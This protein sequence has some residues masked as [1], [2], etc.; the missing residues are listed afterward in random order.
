MA[1]SL[2]AMRVNR[3]MKRGQV[4][5]ALNA[6]GIAITENQLYNFEKHRTSPDVLTAAA[7]IE[8]YECN[9]EDIDFSMP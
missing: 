3:K 5:D 1:V 9:F 8:L 4:V 7:L 2:E 6:K